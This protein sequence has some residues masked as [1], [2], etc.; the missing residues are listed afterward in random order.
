MPSFV[1]PVH[2]TDEDGK[3]GAAI[4]ATPVALG[5]IDPAGV[6]LANTLVLRGGGLEAG[7]DRLRFLAEPGLIEVAGDDGAEIRLDAGGSLSIEDGASVRVAINRDAELTLKNGEISIVDDLDRPRV[8]A[9]ANG[10]LRLADGDT[11]SIVLNAKTGTLQIANSVPGFS[12]GVLIESTGNITITNDALSDKTVLSASGGSTFSK[13]VSFLDNIAVGGGIS[14]AAKAVFRN[15]VEVD[16][17]VILT[18]ADCAENFDVADAHELDPGTVVVIDAGGRLTQSCCAYD[19]RVAGVLS[20]AG[21]FRP[22][23]ILD[24]RES[25]ADRMPLALI[26]K[27]YCKVDADSEPIEV[28]DLLTTSETP[29]HAMRV[30]DP[31]RAVGAILGKALQPLARGRGLIRVL[32]TLQ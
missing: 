32:V 11:Q 12:S 29:G 9:D 26:G 1:A 2:I 28:G 13:T 7:R 22:G 5:G 20:G 15:N 8:F 3:I 17:D 31:S 21:D 6:I 10:A 27:A 25:S 30:G 24:K 14:V 18:G 4:G 16:G 19:R 23:I